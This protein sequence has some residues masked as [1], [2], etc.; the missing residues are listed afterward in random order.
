MQILKKGVFGGIPSERVH[1]SRMVIST[2]STAKAN[3]ISHKSHKIARNTILTVI[4]FLM[5]IVTGFTIFSF[6]ATP[7][8]LVKREIE[9]IATDYYENYF[10]PSIPNPSGLDSYLQSGFARV[11]LRQLLL[12]D[13]RKH[14]ASMEYLSSYCDLDKTQIKVYP[15][16]PF[17]KKSYRV[18]YT[19]SC[20]F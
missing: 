10:Y 9:N 7:E 6:I 13:N 18:E 5:L 8:F 17:E 14:Y 4:L 20:K 3:V 2:S 12:Y 1:V 19:Y 15:E 16:K 11:N